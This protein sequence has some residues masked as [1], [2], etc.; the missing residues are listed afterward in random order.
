MADQ[1]LIAT[2][3][4]LF[5]IAPGRNETWQIREAGFLGSNVSQILPDPRDGS[6]YAALNHGHFGVKLHRSDDRGATWT[7]ITTPAFPEVEPA[8]VNTHTGEPIAP[9]V[10][11]IWSLEPG[12]TDQPGRLWC[13]TIPGGLFRSDDRGHSW[14]LVR[15]LWDHPARREWFGGGADLPGIHSILVDPRDS[16]RVSLGVSCG[17]VWMTTDGG[18]NWEIRAQGMRAA[19]MP[20]E[21]AFDPNIQDPHRVALCRSRPE[22]MWAQHHNG[23]FRT[24]DGGQSWREI[25]AEPSSFGFAVAVHPVE[26]DLAWFVPGVSDEHRLPPNGRVIV[27]RTRDGGRTFETLGRGLPSHHAYDL[28][29]RH[30]LDLDR[31]GNSLVFGTTTGGVWWSRDQG[32]SWTTVSEHLPP[33]YAT[34]FVS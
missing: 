10:S 9:A 5:A 17:G 16:N 13:G 21:R 31:T 14:Q 32:D 22:T 3:K 15:S 7:E 24:D 20:P 27:T 6:W 8:T 34:R 4:G 2:R 29:F 1:A 11:L 23:I 25:S 19:Y 12:G 26:P 30:A 18:Q 33:V 28:T